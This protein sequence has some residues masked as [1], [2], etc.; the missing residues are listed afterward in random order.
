MTINQN[1]SI[2]IG[3]ISLSLLAVGIF[4]TVVFG[5]SIF[6]FYRLAQTGGSIDHDSLMLLPIGLDIIQMSWAIEYNVDPSTIPDHFRTASSPT[7]IADV[8]SSRFF[9]GLGVGILF[10]IL[11]AGIGYPLLRNHNQD[12]E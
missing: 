2:L 8:I 7:Y 6:E 11:G 1:R 5:V 4:A 10:L 9:I 3:G 12:E